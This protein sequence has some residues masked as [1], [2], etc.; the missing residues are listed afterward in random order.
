[1][2]AVNSKQLIDLQSTDHD[3]AMQALNDTIQH[4]SA[5]HATATHRYGDLECLR[6][7]LAASLQWSNS[8]EQTRYV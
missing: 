1:M 5:E 2:I 7:E 3:T 4:Q 6:S 8:A